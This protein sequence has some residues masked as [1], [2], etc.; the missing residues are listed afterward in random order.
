MD[1]MTLA[2]A[3]KYIIQ[4]LSKFIDRDGGSISTLQEVI[5]W[6]E[7]HPEI[8][9][10]L[11]KDI[12][13]IKEDIKNMENLP[14]GEPGK[15]A[16][17]IWLAAGNEGTEEDFL[18]S[19]QGLN[20]EMYSKLFYR[21]YNL[22][23]IEKIASNRAVSMFYIVNYGEPFDYINPPDYNLTIKTGDVCAVGT[24]NGTVISMGILDNSVVASSQGT[25]L[26]WFELLEDGNYNSRYTPVAN[27]ESAYD[28]AKRVN[29]FT[30]TE[31][32]WLASLKATNKWEK[33]NFSYDPSTGIMDTGSENNYGDFDR[34]TAV[35]FANT[36]HTVD[37]IVL[38][39]HVSTN[40]TDEASLK[41]V[42]YHPFAN[43]VTNNP[44]KNGK[45]M[46]CAFRVDIDLKGWLEISSAAASGATAIEASKITTTD[47]YHTINAADIQTP[48]QRVKFVITNSD[49]VPVNLP[50]GSGVYLYGIK[51]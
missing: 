16:Y 12:D 11:V 30:G 9:E 46:G 5:D 26:N 8:V 47:C 27:G 39:V 51:S 31:K 13:K 1:I 6:I 41:F 14:G 25:L 10:S 24:S 20:A 44:A 15:S 43:L 33:I 7:T 42:H 34:L 4:E 40:R 36:G 49:G 22:S 35:V 17:E 32:E 29:K 23:D 37:N 38:Q 21:I 45:A 50:S 18:N 48:V 28:I 2:I 19:L 3:K